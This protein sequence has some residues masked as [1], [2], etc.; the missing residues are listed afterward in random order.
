MFERAALYSI[1]TYIGNK[2]KPEMYAPI[3]S[4]IAGG[5]ADTDKKYQARKAKY[6]VE[7]AKREEWFGETYT[8]SRLIPDVQFKNTGRWSKSK[9]MSAS[10]MMHEDIAEVFISAVYGNVQNAYWSTQNKDDI[11]PKFLNWFDDERRK[12]REKMSVNDTSLEAIKVAIVKDARPKNYISPGGVANL[13]KVLTRTMEQQGA[14]IRSIA[15]VQYTVCRQAGILIP[16]EFI[17]DVAV[18]LSASGELS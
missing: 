10:Y 12:L 8:L 1:V 17:E 4:K 7:V 11:F 15:K 3:Y 14:D 5:N 18:V 6:N 9:R 16:D 13:L 2:N